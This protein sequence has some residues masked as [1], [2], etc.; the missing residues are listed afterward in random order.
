VLA[1][2]FAPPAVQGQIP[3]PDGYAANWAQWKEA[4]RSPVDARPPVPVPAS[5][6]H[7]VAED[8]APQNPVVQRQRAAASGS[9]PDAG[10]AADRLAVRRPASGRGLMSAGEV[11]ARLSS[12]A[13]V[14]P[15][16]YTFEEA[17]AEDDDDVVLLSY[18]PAL[19][20][21]R[22]REDMKTEEVT[23][24][25]E[26]ANVKI[27]HADVKMEAPGPSDGFPV[28]MTEADCPRTAL[29]A[30]RR[31]VAPRPRR[32]SCPGGHTLVCHKVS[33]QVVDLFGNTNCDQCRKVISLKCNAWHCD[34]CVYD[35]CSVCFGLRRV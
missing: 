14:L 6:P 19:R 29:A 3:F 20:L 15:V 24:D 8:A 22:K 9:D 11:R 1:R 7:V 17:P 10:G 2:E 23:I 13:P 5:L 28:P 35:L 33:Q 12:A 32:G 25:L 16:N 27:D 18:T 31:R 26:S 4:T 34:E 21:K 30:R